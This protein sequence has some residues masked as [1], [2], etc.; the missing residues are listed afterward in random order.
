MTA[1]IVVALSGTGRSLRNLIDY[2][3]KNK[4]FEICGV[5]SS[6]EK[7][8]GVTIARESNIDVYWEKF[9]TQ[10]QA[11]PELSAWLKEKKPNLIVLAGFLKVFPT[12]FADTRLNSI[13][14]LNIHPSLLPKFAGK[15]MYGNKVHHAVL[16]AG[17]KETGA[18]IHLVNAV[19]DDG[20]LLAQSKVPVLDGDTIDSLAARVFEAECKLYPQTIEKILREEIKYER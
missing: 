7:I 3:N 13:K 19:Y 18:S 8:L 5:I 6:K 10:N 2:Q 20:P 17:E 11:S 12:D 1:K 9:K 14:I 15:G 4:S 16:E